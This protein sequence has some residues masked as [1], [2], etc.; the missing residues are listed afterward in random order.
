MREQFIHIISSD[1]STTI[2][3]R[4]G[5]QT[6][7]GALLKSKH[8]RKWYKHAQD[9]FLY[10]VDETATLDMMSDGHFEDFIEYLINN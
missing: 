7:A 4:N 5:G 9:N 1:K 8:W 6:I 2:I 3:S 10:E